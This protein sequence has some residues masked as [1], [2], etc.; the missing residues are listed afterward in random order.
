MLVVAPNT[1]K[2]F[3]DRI[4]RVKV[5]TSQKRLAAK[6]NWAFLIMSS[7]SE[8]AKY[9]ATTKRLSARIAF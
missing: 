4:S 6:P 2:K 3:V 7:A 1:A 9:I 8:I 5:S